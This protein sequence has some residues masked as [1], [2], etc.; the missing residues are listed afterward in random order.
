MA[1]LSESAILVKLSISDWL[2]VKTDQSITFEVTSQHQAN[3][4]MGNFR[5]TLLKSPHHNNYRQICRQ[6]MARHYELTLPWRDE[7]MRILPAKLF[8]DY[9]AEIN[10]FKDKAMSAVGEFVSTYDSEVEKVKVEL[11]TMFKQEDYPSVSTLEGKFGIDLSFYPVPEAGDWRVDINNKEVG[12]LKNTLTQEII[13]VQEYS[14]NELW[15]RLTE[16]ISQIHGKLSDPEQRL[17]YDR[18]NNFKK[19]L[20]LAPKLNITSDEDIDSIVK[21]TA[22]VFAGLEA[23]EIRENEELK[24]K[25]INDTKAILDRLAQY[26]R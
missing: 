12:E 21:E 9:V 26:G 23:S 25:T 5:K 6:A 10:T 1:K 18:L 14:V 22:N 20:E 13:K 7:G 2:A 4:N 16:Q 17:R 15:A 19:F 24:Q 3:P 8:Y 11:G